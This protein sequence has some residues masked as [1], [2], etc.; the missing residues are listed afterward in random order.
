[1]KLIYIL[2]FITCTVKIIITNDWE[3][4]CWAFSC[5]LWMLIASKND[6]DNDRNKRNQHSI[7]Y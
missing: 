5:L 7:N 4:R 3:I 2:V 1:M 6:N